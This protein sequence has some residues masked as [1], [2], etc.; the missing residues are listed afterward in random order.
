METLR[1]T[2][3]EIDINLFLVGRANAASETMVEKLESLTSVTQLADRLI[4]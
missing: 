1:V 4:A 2:A 3:Q